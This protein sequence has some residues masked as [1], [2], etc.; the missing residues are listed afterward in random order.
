MNSRHLLLS[1]VVATALSG[2]A[3]S[4]PAPMPS[5]APAPVA[6][7][8]APAPQAQCHADGAKF[9]VGE[10]ASAQ[11]ETAARV[12]AGAESVRILKPN[13]VV[14]L[15]FNGGRLNLVVDARNRVTAV[16]CG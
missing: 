15:E 4:A 14:T 9:A 11:L 3:A 1:V 7:A 10:P 5:P 2:C 12:R 6:A 8:P 13:Q 16:R